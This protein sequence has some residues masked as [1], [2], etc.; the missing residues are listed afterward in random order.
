MLLPVDWNPQGPELLLQWS[1]GLVVFLSV[2]MEI[3]GGK[4]LSFYISLHTLAVNKHII[5]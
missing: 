4:N 5:K 1:L 2:K 3:K